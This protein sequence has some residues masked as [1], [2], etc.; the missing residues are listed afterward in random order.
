MKNALPNKSIIL[1]IEKIIF[2]GEDNDGVVL[3][4]KESNGKTRQV[5]GTL[6][7]PRIGSII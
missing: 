5:V 4:G 2:H 1:S 6:T 3:S 7:D